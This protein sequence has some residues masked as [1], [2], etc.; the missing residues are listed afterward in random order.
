MEVDINAEI[1]SKSLE[2]YGSGIQLV[3]CMEELSELIQAISKEIRSDKDNRNNI[4]KK[5]ADVLIC[6]EILKQV[7][8][9]SEAT[10][11][12]RIAHKQERDLFKMNRH[13]T[14]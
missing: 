3:A 4:I 12:A 5:T 11:D 10:I 9:I 7:F 14:D 6:I 8:G 13:Q 2:T 1:V